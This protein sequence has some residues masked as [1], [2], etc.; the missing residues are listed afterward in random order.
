M[1]FFSSGLQET[2][3]LDKLDLGGYTP[4]KMKTWITKTIGIPTLHYTAILQRP[5]FNTLTAQ[6]LNKHKG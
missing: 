2:H 3:T 4:N 5:E 6:N 1:I